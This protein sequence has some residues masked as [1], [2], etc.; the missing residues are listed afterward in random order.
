MESRQDVEADVQPSQQPNVSA[1]SS[2]QNREVQSSG[3]QPQQGDDRLAQVRIP[4]PLGQSGHG[5][6][7]TGGGP[8]AGG[9]QSV[10]ASSAGVSDD[11]HQ[12]SLASYSSS[13]NMPQSGA[14]AS[15]KL[16]GV[17]SGMG[18]APEGVQGS[19]AQSSG[20]LPDTLRSPEQ[21]AT[22]GY[23]VTD[24]VMCAQTFKIENGDWLLCICVWSMTYAQLLSGISPMLVCSYEGCMALGSSCAKLS[25]LMNILDCM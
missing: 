18:A 7:N 15:G 12:H 8:Q 22:G 4:P 13:R 14:Q 11:R 1:A 25:F 24:T 10:A 20:Q 17:G 6:S 21:S 16:R 23:C 19:A 5:L 9:L 2:L 3:Q